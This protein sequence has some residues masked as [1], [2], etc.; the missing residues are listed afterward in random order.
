MKKSNGID[1]I[2][3]EE[4]KMNVLD[5]VGGYSSKENKYKEIQQNLF[6]GGP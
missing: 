5:L 1:P 2:G 3:V 4:E 6:T